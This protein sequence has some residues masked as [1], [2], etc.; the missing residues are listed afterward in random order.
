MGS[1]SSFRFER[2]QSA[3]RGKAGLH[4]RRYIIPCHVIKFYYSLQYVVS[5][6]V[7]PLWLTTPNA[8]EGSSP[9]EPMYAR[10]ILRKASKL[11]A[12]GGTPVN[13]PAQCL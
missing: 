6:S 13:K 8:D 7:A 11:D 4:E 10:A 12:L 2:S 1:C 5:F 9:I 3:V